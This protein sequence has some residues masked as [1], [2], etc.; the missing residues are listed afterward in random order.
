M[1][2]DKT[3]THLRLAS[4][5][6][7]SIVA[8]VAALPATPALA[9]DA[10]EI[11]VTAQKRSEN[12]QDIPKPVE[13]L[14]QR[15]LTDAG[16]N[17]IGDL[18]RL[19]PS[20]QGT[21]AS[22]APP[23][24]RGISSFA[25]SIGVQAQ[26][27]VVLDDVPQPT[28]ATLADELSDVERV[29][30]LPGPQSTLSG[31]NAAGGLINVVTRNP[32]ST[33]KGNFTAEVTD[34]H[35]KR[36]AGYITG[37]IS[38]KVGFSLSGFW[39]DWDG[40]LK[41]RATGNR[42]GGYDRKGVRGKLRFEP[43]DRFSATLTGFY[44]HNKAPTVGSVAGFPYVAL[45][46]N[47]ASIFDPRPLT[48]LG[49]TAS[50]Y[51]HDIFSGREGTNKSEDYGG[52]LRLEYDADFATISSIT[53]ISHT[54]NPSTQPLV[55]F[56]AAASP[57]APISI[58]QAYKVDYKTQEFRLTSPSAGRFQYTLGAIYTDTDIKQPYMRPV[59]FPVDWDRSALT[60]SFALYGRGT[61]E[62]ATGTFLTGGLRYQHDYQ[63][64]GWDFNSA[65]TPDSAGSNKYDFI[66]GEASIRQEIGDNVSA[67]F[68]YANAQTGKAYDLE[69]QASAST[70]AGLQ[71]LASEKVQN[72]ELGLKTQWL[73]K[74]LT[75]N[76][77]LFNADYKN[78]QIQS[79]LLPE[80][81]GLPS[82]RLLSIGKVRTRGAEITSSFAATPD[83]RLSAAATLLDAKIRDYPNPICYTGQTDQATC[84]VGTPAYTGLQDNLSGTSMP[85]A[86]RFKAVG[87]I[88]YT[89]RLPST[90]VDLTFAAQGRYQTKTHSFVLDDPA[91]DIKAFGTVN[92]VLGVQ[93]HDARYKLQAFVNNV[94]D[95]DYYATLNRDTIVNPVGGSFSANAVYASYARD[96]RRYGGLRLTIDY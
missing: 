87:S 27:G 59:L 72:F 95:K 23:A 74:R 10:G 65:T 57:L 89:L 34:D 79:A 30:I 96:S 11:V 20:I 73:D 88:N 69:D 41:N 70:P 68:T 5:S 77:T 36:F 93:D 32:T 28:F 86:A 40:P 37:P 75:V 1:F 54:D 4:I 12:V 16:I 92:L 9:Q 51:N 43:S 19:S 67:Y 78:Y 33:L 6:T 2:N 94:F 14:N 85:G 49:Y 52:S 82:I 24:I 35:Q 53:S 61:Y 13:V 7:V 84:V 80:G 22:L 64:Y 39:N 15:T 90:P 81:G 26:T 91:S 71:P 48:Q 38:D 76:L 58:S 3:N 45:D 8:L 47:V 17:N 83:L 44:V 66:A 18:A 25:F 56:S 50:P 21:G 31:R 63:R 55:S 42:V 29:E 60:R 46:N 62:V